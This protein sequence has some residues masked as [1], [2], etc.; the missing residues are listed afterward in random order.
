M[1]GI[2]ASFVCRDLEPRNLNIANFAMGLKVVLEELEILQSI[3]CQDGELTLHSDIDSIKDDSNFSIS[4]SIGIELDDLREHLTTEYAGKSH[5]MLSDPMLVT[6]TATVNEKYPSELEGLSL[7]STR[8]IKRN[9]NEM[10]T[11]L[12]KYIRENLLNRDEEHS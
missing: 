10:K 2:V 7:N 4:Y 12:D 6:L 1:Q 9:V 3:F 8:L 5:D 11:K